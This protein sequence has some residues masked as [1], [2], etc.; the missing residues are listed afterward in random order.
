MAEYQIGIENWKPIRKKPVLTLINNTEHIKV[1]SFNNQESADL[2]YKVFCANS[3]KSTDKAIH[4]IRELQSKSEEV[5]EWK[6]T[7]E[8]MDNAEFKVGCNTNALKR[9]V[10]PNNFSYH[11]FKYCPYCGKKIKVVE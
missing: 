5:C 11:N 3:V 7:K 10:V 1:A 8:I 9:G 4:T 2:F 6:Y